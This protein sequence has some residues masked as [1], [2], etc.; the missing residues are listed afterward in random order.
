MKSDN[1]GV[2][3]IAR[4]RALLVRTFDDRLE[5]PSN[6]TYFSSY[7]PSKLPLLTSN[8]KLYEVH[9]LDKNKKINLVYGLRTATLELTDGC[10]SCK[11]ALMVHATVNFSEDFTSRLEQMKSPVSYY[12]KRVKSYLRQLGIEDFWL[13]IEEGK[14][15]QHQVS[16]RLHA[17]IV[18]SIEEYKLNRLKELLSNKNEVFYD[19]SG[20]RER[21][22][23]DISFGY[24]VPIYRSYI[25][26]ER[27]ELIQMEIDEYPEVT[28]WKLP[29]YYQR[30]NGVVFVKKISGINSGLPDYL[31]KQLHKRLLSKSRRNFYISRS[32]TSK[33]YSR[34]DEIIRSNKVAC[35][36]I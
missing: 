15:R 35:N 11:D 4:A 30:S 3:R 5:V 17:H 12:G 21:R 13:V 8:R 27:A 23:V 19:S 20:H 32:L 14:R 33:M 16:R 28:A 10:S 34:V 6:D 29:T 18:L 1:Y 36:M 7:H 25:S 9:R 24:E 2:N 22:A 31:S 26:D